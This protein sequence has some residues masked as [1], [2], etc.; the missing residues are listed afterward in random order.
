MENNRLN[1]ADDAKVEVYNPDGS[2]EG[3][4]TGRGY[5]SV[6]EAIAG[7]FAYID[8]P[9]NPEDYVF[10]VTNEATGTSQRYRVNAGGH[11]RLL[12]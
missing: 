4:H 7:A 11:V 3:I 9:G 5:R 8:A 1:P 12:E 6:S 2:I 10:R